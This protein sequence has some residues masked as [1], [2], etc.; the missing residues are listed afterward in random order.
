MQKITDN[1]YG[2]LTKFGY[3]NQYVIVNESTLTVVDMLLGNSDVNHLEQELAKHDWSIGDVNHMLITHA[4]PDHIGGLPEFQRRSNATT[5]AHRI[6]AQIIRGE[7]D[8]L[9]ANPDELTGFNRLMYR[10]VSQQNRSIEPARVDVNLGDGD[11]LDQILD[12]LEVVHLPG[13]SHG[14][15][16]FYIPQQKLLIGGDVMMRLFGSL[17]MPIRAVS[18]DWIAV[19]QSIR[20]V[21]EMDIDI[22][23][24]GHGN[25]LFN[26][27][28][29][30][31]QF[32]NRLSN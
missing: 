3:L 27:N 26:A 21:A 15:I 5:Y 13:H 1:V 30:I 9:M 17:R 4:H 24:L 20:R 22:L 16:G 11:K 12:G 14:Q 7:A 18:P 29:I 10:Q 25:P 8:G 19:K 6:D 23:C 31:R 28:P 2:I 32:A